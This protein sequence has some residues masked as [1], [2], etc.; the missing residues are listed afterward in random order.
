[1]SSSI[2]A[3]AT[4]N[5]VLLQVADAHLALGGA[6]ARVLTLQINPIT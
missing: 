6:E 4:R 5:Q 3:Q 1:L 2:D